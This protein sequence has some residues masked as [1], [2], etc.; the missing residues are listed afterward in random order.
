MVLMKK[1]QEN[2]FNIHIFIEQKL[3]SIKT[4]VINISFILIISVLKEQFK[5]YKKYINT[6]K[7]E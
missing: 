3:L 2:I 6:I 4:K 7:Y 1:N 5:M